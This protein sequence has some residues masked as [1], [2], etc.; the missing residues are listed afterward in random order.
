MRQPKT[1]DAFLSIAPRYRRSTNVETDF[2]RAE[3]LDGYVL[4]ALALECTQRIVS[5]LA[6]PSGARAWSIVGPYGS[7]KSSFLTY[8]TSLLSSGPNA[9]V[10]LRMLQQREAS[11]YK[12]IAS[13]KKDIGG[14]LFPVIVTGEGIPI[15]RAILRALDRAAE[16][17]WCGPGQRPM[18]AKDIKQAL[19]EA[20]TGESVPDSQIVDLLLGF[21]QK[22]FASNQT[23][24]GVLLVIDE[25]GKL[26]EWASHHPSEADVYLLQL[27]AEAAAR[28]EPGRLGVITV[29]HQGFESYASDLPRR[30]R[31]EWTKIEGRF[32]LI[33]Y[34]ESP[35]HL[36]GLVAN[37]IQLRDEARSLPLFKHC[38]KLAGEVERLAGGELM[39]DLSGCFPLHPATALLLGP[40]FRLRLGQNERS[41]F[42]FLASREPG[43]FQ[44][45]LTQGQGLSEREGLFTLDLLYDYL[46]R[47]TG[48]RIVVDSGD[49]TWASVEQGLSRL[50]ANAQEL[51]VKIV[52]AVALMGMVG[53]QVG[54]RPDSE[55]LA[56]VLDFPPVEVKQALGRLEKASILIF[57][58]FKHAYQV[59]DGSDLNV[60]D[61]VREHRKRVHVAGGLAA[62]LQKAFPPYPV[63]ASRHYHKTG[64]FRFLESVFVGVTDLWNAPPIGSTGD[65]DLLYV[66]PDRA[67]EISDA[68]QLISRLNLLTAERPRAVAIPAD[69]EALID[70]IE[71]FFATFEALEGTPEL[72]S[73]PVARRELE[74]RRL[75]A[76]D[77]VSGALSRSFGVGRKDNA[78][79]WYE[80]AKWLEVRGRPSAVASEIFD[81]AYKK[82]IKVKNELVNRSDLSTAAAAARREL[83][84][85]MITHA[86]QERLGITGHPPELSLYLSVLEATKLHQN[87]NGKFGLVKPSKGDPFYHAWIH[88]DEQLNARSGQ[89]VRLSELMDSLAKP[90]FGMRAGVSP[91]LLF[92]YLLGN[93]D[94]MFLYED[95]AFV[96]EIESDLVHRLLRRPETISLQMVSLRGT[97]GRV[98]KAV[99][100]EI[101]VGVD[102]S[103]LPSILPIVRAIVGVV[104]KLS[105][106]AVQT[107]RISEDARK[108]RAAIRSAKDPVRLLYENLPIALGFPSM[109]GKHEI[110]DNA[111]GQFA[112]KLRAGLK[113]LTAAD[114][115]LQDSIEGELAQM[116]GGGAEE[117]EFRKEAVRRAKALQG[118][119]ELLPMVRRFVDVTSNLDPEDLDSISL[120]RQGLGTAVTGKPPFHWTDAD[121]TRFSYSIMELVRGFVAAEQLLLQRA[122]HPDQDLQMIRV[123]VLDSQGREQ[124]G[125]AVLRKKDEAKIRK[126]QQQTE[127]LA[128]KNGINSADL[129]Y[130]V[131]AEMLNRLNKESR[132]PEATP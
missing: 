33:P 25:A 50:P 36:V 46:V 101:F 123:A 120:W 78:A 91:I 59:W 9:G 84:V 80:Q 54:L 128:S 28:F 66:I 64:T 45:F 16:R 100:E 17:F 99:A 92:A 30:V 3:S 49:R 23:G 105:P 119:G 5:A 15:G 109:N 18:V 67:D 86:D 76:Q 83:M 73:D 42:A 74:E 57:R 1:L 52:K 63:V 95:G 94:Q 77:Q 69:P 117:A 131:I 118:Y 56:V 12:A 62:R 113:E 108:V 24:A 81:R 114:G 11:S 55:G 72:A 65:G 103:K 121:V 96:A 102:V 43:G 40:L 26:L 132:E 87:L 21:T 58:K 2:G 53:S 129:I 35:R 90:P 7:G 115:K 41:L 37:A 19:G 14:P 68:E 29:L 124:S 10:A 13:R 8:L 27:I 110:E 82:T 4:S 32:E 22:V 93:K 89:H 125:V 70:A 75:K 106:Y 51:D 48:L 38:K 107:L 122:S 47:N 34:L 61:L 97:T 98:V 111:F 39:E 85:R 60:G 112:V 44:S 6:S 104:S 20:E 71:E 116:L 79:K 126:F 130:A 127:Q 88:V 31:M